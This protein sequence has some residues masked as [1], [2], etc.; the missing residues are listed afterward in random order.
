MSLRQRINFIKNYLSIGL[1][2]TIC[3]AA[4]PFLALYKLD[5]SL[6]AKYLVFFSALNLSRDI[7]G[8]RL[9]EL[10]VVSSSNNENIT[11]NYL[12]LELFFRTFS[13]L[14]VSL[15][16]LLSSNFKIFYLFISLEFIFY[17][18]YIIRSCHYNGK[19]NSFRSF[20]VVL[21]IAILKLIYLVF[22]ASKG[23]DNFIEY[24]FFISLL[25]VVVIEIFDNKSKIIEFSISK[26]K[27]LIHNQKNIFGWLF[28]DTSLN[29]LIKSGDVFFINILGGELAVLPYKALRTYRGII[30][31]I[32]SKIQFAILPSSRSS[33]K[34][35]NFLSI[36]LIFSC[37]FVFVLDSFILNVAK[38]LTPNQFEL[39]KGIL[40]IAIILEL[41]R[42]SISLHNIYAIKKMKYFQKSTAMFISIIISLLFYYINFFDLILLPSIILI[43]QAIFFK[44]F[45]VK[46]K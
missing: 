15:F 5:S 46:I 23:D 3:Q 13:V 42:C 7:F 32:V 29:S 31:T 12:F 27:V 21:L 10:L 34:I 20:D 28:F 17:G 44:F 2:Y 43:F 18:Y 40:L 16:F 25:S 11:G 14:I 30:D 19:Q 39:V 4:I 45:T 24:F 41:L 6:Y 9:N 33:D 26:T 37:A 38:I 35:V 22:F 1:I 8:L 36:F